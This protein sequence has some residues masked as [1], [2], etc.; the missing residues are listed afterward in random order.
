M[1]ASFPGKG[2]IPYSLKP[3][4][5]ENSTDSES[6]SE[7][8]LEDPVVLAIIAKMKKKE[9]RK[10]QLLKNQLSQGQEILKFR[11]LS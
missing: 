9:T 5:V 4:S 2:D 6:D 8:D 3:S 11:H 10:N 1:S 7:I